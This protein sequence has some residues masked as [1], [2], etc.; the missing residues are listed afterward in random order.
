MKQKLVDRLIKEEGVRLKPYRCSMNKLTIGVG[1]NLEEKGLSKEEAFFLLQ[2]DVEEVILAC[3]KEFVF[4]NT[5]SVSRQIVLADMCFN[6]GMKRLKGFKKMLK[7]IEN[8]D[9]LQASYEMMNSKWAHQVGK[10]AAA[11]SKL[12]K[13]GA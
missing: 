5:L 11:L 1:R 2:N 12:M 8:N 4:F 13:T 6:M 7:A 10:R 9:F 3:Q